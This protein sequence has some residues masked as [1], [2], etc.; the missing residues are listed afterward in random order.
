MGRG[1]PRRYTEGMKITLALLLLPLAALAAPRDE[2]RE[3]P[4]CSKEYKVP[5]APGEVVRL[6][7][8]HKDKNP[9]N[10]LIVHTYADSSCRL[11]GSTEDKAS[12]VDM[13]WRMNA[14]TDKE[15][16]KPTHPKIKSETWKTLEVKGVTPDHAGLKIDITQ[17]EKLEHDLPTSVAEVGLEKG[18]EG[19]T[20]EVVL[21]MGAKEGGGVLR[22]DRIDAEG[23]YTMGVPR[24]EVESLW[25]KGHAGDGEAKGA[26]FESK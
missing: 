17:L 18:G 2:R 24:R 6:L 11:A 3:I 8:L 16:Y 1:A 19:C 5:K 25:L 14:G 13:Y 10:V 21:P 22:I 15:C 26:K 9:Q 12:L 23:K 20:A 4:P 7:E